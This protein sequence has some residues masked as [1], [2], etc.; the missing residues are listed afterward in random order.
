MDKCNAIYS[1]VASLCRCWFGLCSDI[2]IKS[3][4][5]F[6]VLT[7]SWRFFI[8]FFIKLQVFPSEVKHK[9]GWMVGREQKVSAENLSTSVNNSSIPTVARRFLRMLPLS[10]RT[11]FFFCP[12]WEPADATFFAN[13]L[14]FVSIFQGP[15]LFFSFGVFHGL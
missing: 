12:P 5:S 6:R 15:L 9:R 10:P 14:F 11:F 7:H 8:F 13:L 3:N 1:N 4:R 2:F